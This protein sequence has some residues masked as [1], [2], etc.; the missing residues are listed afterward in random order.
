VESAFIAGDGDLPDGQ[1]SRLFV[2]FAFYDAVGSP[3]HGPPWPHFDL[4]D[5][6]EFEQW[7]EGQPSVFFQV[8][9]SVEAVADFF[10][11]GCARVGIEVRPAELSDDLNQAAD[12]LASWRPMHERMADPSR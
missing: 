9:L 8:A 5:I 3:V 7:A 12:V 11:L 6:S 2:R 10:L 1:P 4:S